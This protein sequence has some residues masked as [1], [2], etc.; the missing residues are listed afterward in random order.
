[1]TVPCHVRTLQVKLFVDIPI[2]E[3]ILY[4][5]QILLRY[6]IV[7]WTQSDKPL[8]SCTEKSVVTMSLLHVDQVI[9]GQVYERLDLHLGHL[10]QHETVVCNRYNRPGKLKSSSAYHKLRLK[11]CMESCE[12][13]SWVWKVPLNLEIKTKCGKFRFQV[14]SCQRKAI[15]TDDNL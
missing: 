15:N 4:D 2:V 9:R 1:M 3:E 8:Q 10:L 7:L 5:K 6:G 14:E 11:G 12:V 13:T